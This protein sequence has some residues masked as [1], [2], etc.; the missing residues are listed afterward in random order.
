MSFWKATQRALLAG[1]VIGSTAAIAAPEKNGS[2][3][4]REFGFSA[5]STPDVCRFDPTNWDPAIKEVVRAVLV[6]RKVADV[7]HVGKFGPGRVLII[8]QDDAV[9]VSA[10]GKL[11]EFK[12]EEG[13]ITPATAR[14]K[15]VTSEKVSGEIT[16]LVEE[17]GEVDPIFQERSPHVRHGLRDYNPG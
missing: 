3:P 10:L 15:L 2:T 5:Q 9:F 7:P 1:A 14:D 12:P 13:K 4:P 8:M 16:G 6:F 11:R 17:C